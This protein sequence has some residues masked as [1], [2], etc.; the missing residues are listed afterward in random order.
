MRGFVQACTDEASL[1][2]MLAAGPTAVYAGFD[3]TADSLHLGHLVPIMALAHFQRAGHRSIVLVGGATGMVGDPSGKSDERSLLTAEQVAGNVACVKRQ[4]E[5]FIDFSGS[6]G[7]VLVDNN[8]WIGKMSF[9]DWLRDVGKYFTVNY[10]MAKDCVKRRLEGSDG[11]SYT[12][13]SY[14][15]MQ[16]YDFLHLHDAFGCRVQCG[17][18]DQWGNITAGIDLVRKR[19]EAA[20]FGLTFP[21]ITTASGEKFGKSAGNAVWLDPRRTSPYRF[22]QYLLNTDDRDVER[23]LH[24]FTFVPCERIKETVDAH[25]ASPEKREGQRL[26]A[27]ELTRLVHGE[28][29]LAAALEAS[30]ILFGKEAQGLTDDL[31]AQIAEDVPST[32][33][34]ME[35]LVAGFE[36]TDFLQISGLCK[37]RGEA[38][39]LIEGGGAYLN[40][41]RLDSV[42]R[43]VT[44]GDLASQSALILRSGK[45]SYRVVL[46]R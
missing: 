19:R 3:P 35:K 4:L 24:L 1:K 11:I 37:S 45:K 5:R 38:R 20:A 29:G 15:T 23:F 40:N 16:A 32:T 33:L 41:R 17:G 10:M 6:N 2:E 42:A 46:F 18:S 44:K 26:L 8:D 31:I 12:E 27:A 14:M 22:Y 13:F 30:A 43:V 7:A 34:S 39:R 21:L 36:V 25:R 9:I 28:P